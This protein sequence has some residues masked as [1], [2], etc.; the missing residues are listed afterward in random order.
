VSLGARADDESRF[1]GF[2]GDC[3]SD[4]A[5]CRFPIIQ[6][7]LVTANFGG[8]L[9]SDG[10]PPAAEVQF[11]ST[12]QGSSTETCPTGIL[13]YSLGTQLNFG[14]FLVEEMERAVMTGSFSARSVE[15]CEATG[16]LSCG[17]ELGGS[18]S[19]QGSFGMV[20]TS[21]SASTEVP[22]VSGMWSMKINGI[23]KCITPDGSDSETFSA[24]LSVEME[25]D[26]ES[27]SG[28]GT[29]LALE[30]GAIDDTG[31]G[32]PACI[33]TC[34]GNSCDDGTFFPFIGTVVGI[35]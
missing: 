29:V 7:A 19:V 17:D 16:T 33:E 28:I 3:A 2:S 23:Q 5:G 1:I 12:I 15:Q 8:S 18:C 10:V 4:S 26:G 30:G 9:S 24:D 6:N 31:P 25:Q 13:S 11:S 20:R 14:G 22:D 32:D 21:L 34:T 27:F 35:P